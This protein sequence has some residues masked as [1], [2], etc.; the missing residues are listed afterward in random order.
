M[1]KYAFKMHLKPGCVDEY[2]RRHDEIWPRLVDLLR[3]SG[4]RDYSIYL[5][6]DTLTLFGVL[7]RCT[8]HTMADLPKE[9]LMQEWWK[10]MADLMQ[11]H[12]N[13]EPVATPLP[14]MFHLE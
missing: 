13:N 10:Y 2:R 8:N 3:V 7:W 5:D 14:C 1:E 11:T 4:V 12:P 9:A 6:E